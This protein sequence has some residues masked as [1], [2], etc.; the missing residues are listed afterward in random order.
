[1]FSAWSFS[2]VSRASSANSEQVSMY[3][4]RSSMACVDDRL[5]A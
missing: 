5:Y 2:K 1:M 4:P 3:A